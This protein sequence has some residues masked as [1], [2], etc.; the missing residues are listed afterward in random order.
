MW[1]DELK[2]IEQ[3]IMANRKPLILAVD[4]EDINRRLVTELLEPEGYELVL[5]MNGREG[6]E[7]AMEIRPDTILLDWMMPEMTGLEACQRLKQD[8]ATAHIPVLLVTSLS[9]REDR[10]KGIEAGANDFL[11]KPIDNE[12]LILRVKNAVYTKSLFDELQEKYRQVQSL[13][14]QRECLTRMIV[15]DMR[16]PLTGLDGML[17][18]LEMTAA[19]A[20]NPKQTGY[21]AQARNA[22]IRLM[23]M[24]NSLLDIG[25][26]EEG[27]MELKME[28]T[29]LTELARESIDT[30][31]SVLSAY[32]T[33][34]PKEGYEG[35]V[36][37]DCDLI[38]RS[39]RNLLCNAAKVTGP[40]ETIGMRVVSKEG[41]PCLIIEDGGTPIPETF[42][43]KTFEKFGQAEMRESGE[44]RAAGLGLTFCKMA[45]EAHGGS[46]GIE[47]KGEKGNAFWFTLP[48][49]GEAK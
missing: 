13:E 47:G 2:S 35:D 31:G 45:V 26:F 19:S 36:C 39:I 32:V 15:H 16:S 14:G 12:D 4:D 18:L 41:N 27:K 20:L 48:V 33:D 49:T 21:L 6:L 25:R 23:D 1:I 38:R 46:I 17:Q 30:L 7:K 28:N 43:E 24:V 40:G 22:G 11:N 5:A 10:L 29:S 8:P 42:R 3:G 34:F 44:M 37:C 9:E